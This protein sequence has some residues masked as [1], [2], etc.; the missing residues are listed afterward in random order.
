MRILIIKLSSLGDVLHALPAVAELAEQ[1]SAE[2]D[3][4]VQPAFAPL[5]RTFSCVRHV[6]EVSRPSKPFAYVSAIRRIRRQRYDLVVDF[7]GLLKSAF[8]ARFAHAE[9]R[10]GPSFAREGSRFFYTELAG[11]LNKDRHAVDEC[12]DV[13]RHLELPVPDLARFPI[14][15]PSIDLDESAPLSATGPRIALA[16]LSRWESKNWPAEYFSALL[17]RLVAAHDARVYVIGGVDDRSVCA[18]IIAD[19][20]VEAANLCGRFSLGD[21]LGVL[22]QCEALVSNDS[23]PMHMGAALGVKCVV[24]FGPTLPERTGPYGLNHVILRAGVPCAPCYKRKCPIGTHVC[25][26]NITPER[27]EQALFG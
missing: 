9:R 7:Q 15:V 8:V 1:Y 20:G 21:S 24:P 25:L 13:L 17:K 23:G 22:A 2:V 10:I 6:Y 26:R 4:A 19:A 18:S 12:F 14:T 3:W 27:V 5:V 11:K 16:P